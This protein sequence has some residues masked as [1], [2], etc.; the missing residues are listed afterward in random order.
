MRKGLLEIGS[1][2][3]SERLVSSKDRPHFKT[4]VR[5]GIGPISLASAGEIELALDRVTTG[6]TH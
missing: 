3:H 4:Y 1:K 5:C 2:R 6:E